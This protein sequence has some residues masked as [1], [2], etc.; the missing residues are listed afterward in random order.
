MKIKRIYIE[1]FRNLKNFEITFEDD[2]QVIA[3]IGENGAGKSTVLEVINI[4][5]SHIAYGK[6]EHISL[7]LNGD[8]E[9]EYYIDEYKYIAKCNNK[10]YSIS[11]ENIELKRKEIAVQSQCAP[12]T[13][14]NYYAGETKRLSLFSDNYELGFDKS[15]SQSL[16]NDKPLF[17]PKLNQ[18]TIKDI[19]ILV[20]ANYVYN[21]EA[22]KKAK[23]MLSIST[24][25]NMVEGVLLKPK[26]A[27]KSSKAINLWNAIGFQAKFI[28]NI[29]VDIMPVYNMPDRV[30]FKIKNILDL[31]KYSNT[32]YDLF[33]KLKALKYDGYLDYLQVKINEGYSI[34]YLSE[35]QK[36][37]A[38]LYMLLWL[39][40]EQKALFLLDEFDVYLHPT[41][42]R[43]F[44]RM[45]S[46][47]NIRG[48][49]LFT[50][51]SPATISGLRQESVFIMKKGEV[52]LPSSETYNRALDEIMEEQM[53]VSMRP[54]EFTELE[55][56]FRNAVMHGDKT[57]AL[58]TLD[59]IKRIVGEEDPFFI[60]ARMALKRME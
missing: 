26:W 1:K 9:V 55:K 57:K 23:E 42:Q 41:W 52:Y 8:F 15:Y 22:W 4:I 12:A 6:L 50:T 30:E 39:T 58:K 37:L 44:I 13:I 2:A 40:R 25:E 20:I 43:K 11:K 17:M 7:F 53:G 5:F 21:T 56:V 49:I 48:Q 16:I 3:F 28:N 54:N 60:T 24:V 34:K 47:I 59:K 33:V 19:D 32:P 35:G 36:Q 31:K 27:G 10:K 45:I 51:H 38:C 18:V 29:A 46:D 14:H